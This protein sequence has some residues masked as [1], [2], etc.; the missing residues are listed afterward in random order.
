M[1]ARKKPAAKHGLDD[2]SPVE[3]AKSISIWKNFEDQIYVKKIILRNGMF[4]EQ[5]C[6]H[7]SEK[8]DGNPK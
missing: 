6:T 5:N 7:I 8:L 4:P 2:K 1:K 3:V